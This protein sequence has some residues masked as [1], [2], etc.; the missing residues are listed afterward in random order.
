MNEHQSVVSCLSQKPFARE[1]AI[2]IEAIRPIIINLMKARHPNLPTSG[3]VGILELRPYLEQ[4]LADLLGHDESHQGEAEIGMIGDSMHHVIS[5]VLSKK[6]ISQ[7]W[8]EQ[9]H[10]RKPTLGEELADKIA[11]FGGSWTFIML[12]GSV[13]FC[14][15]VLNSS[16]PKGWNF[17]PYP[18]IFLNL[19]LSCVAAI[20]AP[21]IMMSQ[22][23]QETKDRERALA[24]YQVNLKSELE[25]RLLHEKVDHLTSLIAELNTKSAG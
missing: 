24:D 10:H 8:I 12:F 13:I 25:I 21:V 15:I 4:H 5:H 11:A 7:D 23:R 16:L 9:S 18:F 20:Q 19:I 22:N 17:D 14:W 6:S 3:Y 2:R 1:E